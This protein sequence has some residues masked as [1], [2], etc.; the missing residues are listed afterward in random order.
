MR[1]RLSVI[2]IFLLLGAIVNVAI[3]WSATGRQQ[4]WVDRFVS[5]WINLGRA[6]TEIVR[7]ESNGTEIDWRFPIYAGWPAKGL[8]SQRFRLIK[9]DPPI[10]EKRV[11]YRGIQLENGVCLPLR[12]I[13]PGFAAN[14]VLYAIILWLLSIAF[15]NLR[16]RRRRRRGHC[17]KCNY[18]LRGAPAPGSK[19]ATSEDENANA[20]CPECGWI[21]EATS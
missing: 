15:V 18:D 8:Q 14:M 16:Q 3:A 13:W 1:R 10:R 20:I 6:H 17:I 7:N 4:T 11:W 5:T 9:D 19:R 21:R 12:P 2:L